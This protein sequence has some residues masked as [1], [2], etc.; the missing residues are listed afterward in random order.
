MSKINAQ[1]ILQ[2]ASAY[3]ILMRTGS[4]NEAL[5]AKAAILKRIEEELSNDCLDKIHGQP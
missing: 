5:D 3:E 1:G 4:T 2:L